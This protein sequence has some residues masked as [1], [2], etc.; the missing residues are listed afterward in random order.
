[1]EWL[2]LACF[3][4][5]VRCLC[6]LHFFDHI[7]I[8]Y[9]HKFIKL[10]TLLKTLQLAVSVVKD[11]EIKSRLDSCE[12]HLYDLHDLAEEIIAD[13]KE[14]EKGFILYFLYS[15]SFKNTLFP[16]LIRCCIIN[17]FRKDIIAYM[18][19]HIV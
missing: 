17:M 18:Y 13:F 5:C 4:K 9:F 15:Q 11:E 10:P 16:V 6:N 2:T 1:M 19:T 14:F 12:K 8:T 3:M 7:S